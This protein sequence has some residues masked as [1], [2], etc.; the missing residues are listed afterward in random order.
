MER[1]VKVKDSP[2][3]YILVDSELSDEQIR[4]NWIK[5]YNR[6]KL[7]LNTEQK[8]RER[9]SIRQGKVSNRKRG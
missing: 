4:Y 3:T 5:R 1:Q 9:V 8:R 2:A 6:E 7:D